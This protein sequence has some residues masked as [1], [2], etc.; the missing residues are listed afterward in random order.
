METFKSWFCFK[1]TNAGQK[2]WRPR[3]M[4]EQKKS[5]TP[6]PKTAETQISDSSRDLEISW[7]WI[8]KSYFCCFF[9]WECFHIKRQPLL[10]LNIIVFV[11]FVICKYIVMYFFSLFSNQGKKRCLL[12]KNICI[13]LC[14]VSSSDPHFVNLGLVSFSNMALA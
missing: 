5:Q 7:N 1:P 8:C 6:F 13:D 3:G 2:Y 14:S 12:R 9:N 10:H 11:I 4:F